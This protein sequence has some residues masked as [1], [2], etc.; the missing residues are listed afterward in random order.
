MLILKNFSFRLFFNPT[1][2]SASPRQGT[3]VTWPVPRPQP[4]STLYWAPDEQISVVNFITV[5]HVANISELGDFAFSRNGLTSV[6]Y[7]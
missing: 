4:E 5:G 7:I 6:F 1:T 3:W 2:A